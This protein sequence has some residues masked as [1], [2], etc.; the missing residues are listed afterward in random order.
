MAHDQ[1]IQM[2]DWIVPKSPNRCKD[3]ENSSASEI[4][5]IVFP[6]FFNPCYECGTSTEPLNQYVPLTYSLSLSA[7]SPERSKRPKNELL[8]SLGRVT[9]VLSEILAARVC[10]GS[11][12]A[13]KKIIR[14]MLDLTANT[15]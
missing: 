14:K 15:C 7:R 12:F 3:K 10:G 4:L 11:K 2:Q 1:S 6:S 5:E 9:T 8:I 13:K